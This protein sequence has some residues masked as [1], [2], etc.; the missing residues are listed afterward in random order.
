M[1]ESDAPAGLRQV[2]ADDADSI[3]LALPGASGAM[4]R[5]ARGTGTSAVSSV[6]LGPVQLT[7]MELG[8][9]MAGEAHAER[10]GLVFTTVLRLPGA[11]TWDGEDLS[12]GETYLYGPGQGQIANDP[13]GFVLGLATIEWGAFETAAAHLHLDP[14]APTG[15]L[16]VESA[17]D[18]S[19]FAPLY[20]ELITGSLDPDDPL[21]VDRILGDSVEL[22]AVSTAPVTSAREGCRRST[23]SRR[24]AHIWIEP[25]AGPCPC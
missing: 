1:P 24:S 9:P 8:F 7:V 21:L 15:K 5:T 10:D 12:T 2:L 6:D 11:G 19:T 22:R 3:L 13:D 23:S 18:G 4:A 25:V 16:L 14:E 17:S 20:D